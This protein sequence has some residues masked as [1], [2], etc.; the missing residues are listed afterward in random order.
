MK[1]PV[2]SN[3]FYC[4]ISMELMADPV[5]CKLVAHPI[6]HEAPLGLRASVGLPTWA[7]KGSGQPELMSCLCP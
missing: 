5:G 1:G 4:P 7:V 6:R 3:S 2:A